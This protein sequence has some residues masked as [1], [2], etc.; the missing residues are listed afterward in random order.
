M[1][2]LP[3]ITQ[4]SLVQIQPPQPKNQGVTE[5]HSVTPSYFVR[6]LSVFSGALAVKTSGRHPK[7]RVA[8][9]RPPLTEWSG[10]T[11]A[12]VGRVAT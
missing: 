7:Q 8:H 9:A 6:V 12:V 3:L 4:R 5:R 11:R 10:T 2:E 1:A